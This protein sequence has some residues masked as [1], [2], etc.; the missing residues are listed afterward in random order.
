MRV[1]SA[2]THIVAVLSATRHV[3]SAQ[4]LP[5][6][7]QFKT[8][9]FVL[10]G[11]KAKPLGDTNEIPWAFAKFNSK[12]GEMVIGYAPEGAQNLPEGIKRWVGLQ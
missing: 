2:H 11:L 5:F 6:I 8:V 9:H 10:G 1:A 7:R 3:G 4:R 12:T